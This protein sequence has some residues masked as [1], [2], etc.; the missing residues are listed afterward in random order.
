MSQTKYVNTSKST[1]GCQ[2][3]SSATKLLAKVRNLGVKT[4]LNQ[5]IPSNHLSLGLDHSDLT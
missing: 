4:A 1:T 5:A 2:F 3:V